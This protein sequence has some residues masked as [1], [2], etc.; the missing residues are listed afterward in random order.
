MSPLQPRRNNVDAARLLRQHTTP[1]EDILWPHLRDRRLTGLKFRR[2]HPVGPFVL[3]FCCPTVRLAIE[4]DGPVHD[5]QPDRDENRTQALTASGYHVLRFTNDAVIHNL[6]TVL[7]QIAAEAH[8]LMAISR[9]PLSRAP[10]EGAGGE[11]PP[12]PGGEG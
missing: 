6:D 10:G 2:Q 5:Q 4:L 8:R 12:G 7:N 3:D 1:A 11:G 9:T